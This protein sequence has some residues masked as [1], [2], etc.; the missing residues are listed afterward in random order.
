MNEIASDVRADKT[1]GRRDRFPSR[2]MRP[3]DGKSY[4]CRWIEDSFTVH[5][6]GNVTCGL[7]DPFAE[8]SFGNVKLQSIETINQNPEYGLIITALAEGRRCRNCQLFEEISEHNIEPK[9]LSAPTTLIVEPTILCNLR[10]PQQ[11][12]IPNNRKS[13]KTRE[14]LSLTMDI[15]SSLIN[16]VRG[17][18]KYVY[19]FNYGDPFMHR[20]AEDMLSEITREIP[21]AKITTSTNAIP[22]KT[23]ARAAAVVAAGVDHIT[24]T[25]SGMTQKSY[26]RYH[27]NGTLDHALQG[28]R[29]LAEAKKAQGAIKPEI[30]W[31]YLLF[32]WT[33]NEDQIEAAI[34]YVRQIDVNLRLYLTMEPEGAASYRLSP[35]SPMYKKYRDLIDGAHGY[36]SPTPDDNGFYE[37]EDFEEFGLGRWT[38]H[39]AR[40]NYKSKHR[41]VRFSLATNRSSDA[42]KITVVKAITPWGEYQLPI[43]PGELHDFAL[44]IPRGHRRQSGDV[45]L[46]TDDYWFPAHELES[47]DLRCL[48]VIVQ[49]PEKRLGIAGWVRAHRLNAWA[50]RTFKTTIGANKKYWQKSTP[51]APSRQA[52]FVAF[53]DD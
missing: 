13:P 32:R 11:S 36:A 46:V 18:V 1:A 48:G 21:S 9:R 6:D 3:T 19:F 23:K 5:S 51:L 40:I 26:E 16:Q 14:A 34:R 42:K 12:C 4:R 49:R 2:S 7:D 25:I 27:V 31:R 30:V 38:C 43:S 35:G 45:Y 37:Q 17:S 29:N 39:E 44:R 50:S 33:D 52:R 47:S 28:M 53:E 20:N 8:R 24:C 15:F 41:W 22:L 10:C